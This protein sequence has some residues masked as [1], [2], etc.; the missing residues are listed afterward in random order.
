MDK[1]ELKLTFDIESTSPKPINLILDILDWHNYKAIFFVPAKILDSSPAIFLKIRNK[2]HEIGLHGYKHERFDMLNQQEKQK[3]LEKSIKIYKSL[4]KTAPECF[5][6]PQFSADFELLNLLE[7]L[8]FKYDSSIVQFPI[9]QA[10]FFPSKISL[11]LKHLKF[12]HY[13]NKHNLKIKEMPVSSFIFPISML[14]LRLL[15][16][17]IFK[18]LSS[19]SLIFRRDKKI[20][21]LAH[22]YEFDTKNLNKFKKFLISVKK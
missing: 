9:S 21:F 11:Y 10:I 15:P 12:N 19:L 17:F 22:S 8:K 6:A 14:S 1:M 7:E 3:I 2:G 4:F 13:I 20:V 18:I 16:L 5:R